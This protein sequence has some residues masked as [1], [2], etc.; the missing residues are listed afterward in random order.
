M[1]WTTGMAMVF[2][3]LLA[4]S[5][6]GQDPAEARDR[7]E[8]GRRADGLERT[9]EL[10]ADRLIRLRSDLNLTNDQVDR[11]KAAQATSRGFTDAARLQMRDLRDALRD[12]EITRDELRTEMSRRRT[13]AVEERLAHRR[14]LDAVLDDTQRELVRELR[15]QTAPG[16]GLRSGSRGRQ[17]RR[18]RSGFR[19][20][21]FRERRMS[22]RRFRRQM[23]P[24]RFRRGFGPGRRISRRVP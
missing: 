20:Q 4:H 7:F 21:G 23:M 2:F 11:I 1:K 10:S 6:Q 17:L 24:S 18:G 8:R 22:P 13:L 19:G 16:R 14:E 9:R 5:I 12:D 3:S 15:R